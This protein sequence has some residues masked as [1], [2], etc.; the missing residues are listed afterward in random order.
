MTRSIRRA[1]RTMRLAGFMNRHKSLIIFL[2]IA[3]IVVAFA[4]NAGAAPGIPVDGFIRY[5]AP[6][7]STTRVSPTPGAPDAGHIVCPEEFP[8]F[9]VFQGAIVPQG[10]AT[11]H[12]PQ[13]V[14]IFWFIVN[15]RVP[16]LEPCDDFQVNFR[17][18]SSAWRSSNHGYIQLN[19]SQ[20]AAVFPRD[21]D[22]IFITTVLGPTLA[23]RPNLQSFSWHEFRAVGTGQSMVGLNLR[24]D[25][26]HRS[27]STLTIAGLDS[28]PGVPY[29]YIID[30]GGGVGTGSSS[31]GNQRPPAGGTPGQPDD[32]VVGDCCEADCPSCHFTYPPP[33]LPPDSPRCNNPSCQFCHPPCVGG[34]T[35]G[36]FDV[37][38]CQTGDCPNRPTPGNGQ[39]GQPGGGC[40]SSAPGQGTGDG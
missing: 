36:Q 29:D 38:C 18:L 32:G 21:A 40:C 13:D 22:K 25:F 16:V 24:F 9:A 7:F 17:V 1:A 4:T 20:C 8:Y 30:C 33:G 39:P 26:W 31:G 15:S 6:A 2:L 28:I 3:A 11:R 27:C 37:G 35:G 12:R 10:P 19:I 23:E 14:R 5:R 34:C